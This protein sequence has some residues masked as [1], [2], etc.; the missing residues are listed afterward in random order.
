MTP[1]LARPEGVR[2]QKNGKRHR[3]EHDCEQPL[4]LLQSGRCCP[5]RSYRRRTGFLTLLAALC[6]LLA[7][8]AIGCGQCAKPEHSDVQRAPSKDE[9]WI[10][11]AG[12]NDDPAAA[13]RK[14]GDYLRSRGV[15]PGISGTVIHQLTVAE[16]EVERATKLIQEYIARTGD[17]TIEIR[18]PGERCETK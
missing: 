6:F 16:S 15:R 2:H 3:A 4:L 1:H 12:I 13:E 18:K 5:G 9:R 14:I 11:V 8:G 7:I 10:I 17:S